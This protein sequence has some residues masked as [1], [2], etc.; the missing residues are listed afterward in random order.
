MF[1]QKI[2]ERNANLQPTV[3]MELEHEPVVGA[4][5]LAQKMKS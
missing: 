2:V 4:A 3:L 5:L 1:Q